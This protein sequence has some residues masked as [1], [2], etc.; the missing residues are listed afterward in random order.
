MA[1]QHAELGPGDALYLPCGW[2]HA[3]Q[4]VPP[5]HEAAV[6]ISYWAHQPEGIT[7]FLKSIYHNPICKAPMML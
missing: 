4:T 3:V 5:P 7:S 1:A 6:S 2:W